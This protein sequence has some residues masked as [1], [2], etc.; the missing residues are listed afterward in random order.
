MEACRT[1]LTDY[2]LLVMILIV[3]YHGSP[4]QTFLLHLR[5]VILGFSLDIDGVL[6]LDS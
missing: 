4:S 5:H 2:L 6:F 1:H 3:F